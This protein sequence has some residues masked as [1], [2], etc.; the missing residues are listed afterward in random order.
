MVLFSIINIGDS[1]KYKLIAMDF[2]GTLLTTDKKITEKNKNTILKYK[3]MGYIIVGV[4]ARTLSSVKSVSDIN[5]FNY[6]ILNNGSYLYDVK[7]NQGDYKGII[8]PADYYNITEELKDLSMRIDYCSAY[9]YYYYKDNFGDNRSFI[10]NIDNLEEIKEEIVRMNVHML[11]Q[12]KMD[13][14]L[15]V[16]NNNYK[17]LNCF[18]MQ[19]SDGTQKWLVIN[20][21][22]IN[23]GL[24]LKELGEKLNIN[25]DEMIF[26]GDGPNDLEVLELVG[27]SVAMENALPEVKEKAKFIT[28]SNNEDGIAVFLE[29]ISNNN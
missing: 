5:M 1:M 13:Y 12:D 3:N 27:C 24:A 23:K 20:P 26:F 10:K 29:K 2:D 25:I 9:S 21:K 19:D 7:N 14:C 22:D 6:L 15:N 8:S 18:I 11:Y 28:L 16:I 4:T 17:N